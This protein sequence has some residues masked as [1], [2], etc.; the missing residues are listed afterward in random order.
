M[1]ANVAGLKADDTKVLETLVA[2]AAAVKVDVVIRDEREAALRRVLNLGHTY[3][4]A[5]E[6]ATGYRR[7]LHGE[8]VAWG[9]LMVT[10]LS[11]LAGVIEPRVS[12]RIVRL[13]RSVGPL[14]KLRGI[15]EEKVLGLLIRDKKAVGGRVHWVLPQAI[16]KVRVTP[17]VPDA[18]VATAFRDVQS[19]AW[20]G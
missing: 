16:G 20:N 1:E 14:P 9:M 3:G 12:K 17:D 4:H 11:E 18:N 7:F 13:V 5:L 6:E 8:A 15:Q 10:R 2:R 19:G